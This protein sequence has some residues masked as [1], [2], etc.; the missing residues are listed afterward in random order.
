M[1]IHVEFYGIPR[2]RAGVSDTM[3]TVP[4]TPATLRDVIGLLAKRFPDLAT[5]CFKGDL[6]RRGYVANVGGN[7][8]IKSPDCPLTGTES[9]LILSA[10][11]GG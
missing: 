11:A 7:Q 9:L 4:K 1:Q 2:Q 8:F 5:D 6:L 3:V 10:D